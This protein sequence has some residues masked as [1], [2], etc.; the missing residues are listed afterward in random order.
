[1]CLFIAVLPVGCNHASPPPEDHNLPLSDNTHS[2]QAPQPIRSPKLTRDCLEYKDAEIK[3]LL[4][5][6][7]EICVAGGRN[8]NRGFLK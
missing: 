1:V 4:P 7:S 8:T 5:V 2:G 6:M 3:K